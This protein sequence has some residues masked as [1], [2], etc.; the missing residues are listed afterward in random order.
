MFR[1]RVGHINKSTQCQAILKSI[2]DSLDSKLPPSNTTAI[3]NVHVALPPLP[4]QSECLDIAAAGIN[5]NI[6]T[7]DNSS[8]DDNLSCTSIDRSLSSHHSK[9]D[10]NDPYDQSFLEY[11]HQHTT[12]IPQT[13]ASALY[14]TQEELHLSKLVHILNSFQAPLHAYQS[15]LKWVISM[16]GEHYNVPVDFPSRHQLIQHLHERMCPSLPIPTMT[17]IPNSTL[18]IPINDWLRNILSLL[19]SP[20]LMQPNFLCSTD[21]L[22]NRDDDMN[23]IHSAEWYS[24][25]CKNMI[26]DPRQEVVMG[27]ILYTDKTQLTNFAHIGLEPLLFMLTIFRRQMRNQSIF[28]RAIAYVPDHKDDNFENES[29]VSLRGQFIFIFFI[30]SNLKFF[31]H[32]HRATQQLTTFTHTHYCQVLRNYSNPHQV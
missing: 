11:A 21:P 30:I 7:S 20:V 1:S 24:K 32:M 17:P 6:P 10:I 16:Q 27:I 26:T 29:F 2:E 9:H 4:L 22:A 13:P 12:T 5:S 28:W 15:I 31:H 25:T 3:S 23:D 19:Q 18:T 8:N 14:A